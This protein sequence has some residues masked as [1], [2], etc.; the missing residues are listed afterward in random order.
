MHERTLKNKRIVG[1]GPLIR[2]FRMSAVGPWEV[3]TIFHLRGLVGKVL[4]IR[5]P[6]FCVHTGA[7][8]ACGFRRDGTARDEAL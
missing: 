8:L 3:R 1:S 5:I 2:A 4:A 7:S 6:F